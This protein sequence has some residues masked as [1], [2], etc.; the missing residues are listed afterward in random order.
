MMFSFQNNNKL[1]K[2]KLTERHKIK[3]AVIKLNLLFMAPAVGIE[4]T[5]NLKST[6]YISIYG[7]G[8]TAKNVITLP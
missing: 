3:K 7:Y 2:A 8:L 5:R 4:P 6:Y 1:K